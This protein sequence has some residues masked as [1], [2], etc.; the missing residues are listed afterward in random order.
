VSIITPIV[1]RIQY[2][3]QTMMFQEYTNKQMEELDSETDYL[4]S[5]LTDHLSIS[6][7][8]G[9]KRYTYLHRWI[10]DK[11]RVLDTKLDDIHFDHITGYSSE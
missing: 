1:Y 4:Y 11:L 2:L 7:T 3:K 6:H 8:A 5:I 9:T 10:Q